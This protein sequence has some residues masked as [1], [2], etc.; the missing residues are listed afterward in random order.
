M[1]SSHKV[2]SYDHELGHPTYVGVFICVILCINQCGEYFV[3]GNIPAF[4]ILP[5][6]HLCTSL[7]LPNKIFQVNQPM[8]FLKINHYGNYLMANVYTHDII[9]LG[10][11]SN[12]CYLVSAHEYSH[13]SNFVTHQFRLDNIHHKE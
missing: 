7:P 12:R 10:N 6:P 1:V 13:L 3:L 5:Q 9:P 8:P 11:G 2:P 4:Q